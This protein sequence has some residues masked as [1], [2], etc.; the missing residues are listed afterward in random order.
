MALW[1]L[2]GVA[3]LVFSIL[4]GV[5]EGRGARRAH[6]KVLARTSIVLHPLPLHGYRR[7]RSSIPGR[8]LHHGGL[9]IGFLAIAYAVTILLRLL[10]RALSHWL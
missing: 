7:V 8:I 4:A 10:W 6:Q 9:F 2:M 1:V 5:M 3:A